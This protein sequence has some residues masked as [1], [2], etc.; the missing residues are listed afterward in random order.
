M[1]WRRNCLVLL[2]AACLAT[3]VAVFAAE[4]PVAGTGTITWIYDA[5]TVEVVPYGKVR[6]LGIDAPEKDPSPRDQDFIAL[7]IP[8]S[9]LRQVHDA[10]LAWAIRNLKGKPVTLSGEAPP[11]DRH[12]RLLAYLHLDD[13]R[14]LNQLLLEQGLVM[15]YRRFDFTRKTAF[16]AAEAQARQRRVGLWAR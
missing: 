2:L 3:A 7:G 14:L 12:G 13:G 11:R 4:P 1:P 8:R 16:L 6:L 10:G 5:D 9:R 15:V